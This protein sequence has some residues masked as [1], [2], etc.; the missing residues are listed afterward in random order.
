MTPPSTAK[1]PN[2]LLNLAYIGA[3]F[4]AMTQNPKTSPA[5]R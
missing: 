1:K 4:L 5:E 2:G 3:A